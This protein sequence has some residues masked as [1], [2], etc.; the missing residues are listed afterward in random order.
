MSRRVAG[1]PSPI[2]A[3]PEHQEHGEADNR[4]G[5]DDHVT[6]ISFDVGYPLPPNAKK[7]RSS[8]NSSDELPR[9]L[10]RVLETLAT[11]LGA[12][13]QLLATAG[14][15]FGVPRGVHAAS[16]TKRLLVVGFRER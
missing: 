3:G 9:L 10:L 4:D 7:R 1:S 6:Y 12:G 16:C 11:S 8:P 14:S 15:L 2:L 5:D 13:P